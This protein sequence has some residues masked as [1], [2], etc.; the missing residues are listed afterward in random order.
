MSDGWNADLVTNSLNQPL[1]GNGDGVGGDDYSTGFFFLSGDLNHDRTVDADDYS[2]IACFLSPYRYIRASAQAEFKIISSH[3]SGIGNVFESGSKRRDDIM[4]AFVGGAGQK[5]AEFYELPRGKINL[6][7]LKNGLQ[8]LGA[9]A[10]FGLLAG[11]LTA[12]PAAADPSDDFAEIYNW[13]EG[14]GGSEIFVKVAMDAYM[15]DLFRGMA[16]DVINAASVVIFYT[17]LEDAAA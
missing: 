14:T 16:D 1:D 10:I 7:V 2:M 17:N 12:D 6:K 8:A 13:R 11:A 3:G 4:R 5:C 15:R 9:L